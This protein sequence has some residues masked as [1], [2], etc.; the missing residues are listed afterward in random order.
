M[1]SKKHPTNKNQNKKVAHKLTENHKITKNLLTKI[2]KN[3][4]FAHQ[5]SNNY[6]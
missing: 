1:K 5:E 2:Y 4:T 6:T 3:K